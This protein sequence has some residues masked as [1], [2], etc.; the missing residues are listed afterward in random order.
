MLFF[1]T[2]FFFSKD[3]LFFYTSNDVDGRVRW[4]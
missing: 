2:Y 1:I 3:F 4:K